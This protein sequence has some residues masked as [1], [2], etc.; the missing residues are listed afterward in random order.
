MNLPKRKPTR[1]KKFDYSSEGYYFVTICTHNKKCILS[2]VV[3]QGLAPAENI[4]LKTKTA[5]I[6]PFFALYGILSDSK[7][8]L[9]HILNPLI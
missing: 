7:I 5:E 3:G 8:I 6:Q 4:G 1:L 9:G 2:N